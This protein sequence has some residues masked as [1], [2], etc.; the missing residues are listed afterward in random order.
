MNKPYPFAML[1]G[2]FLLSPLLPAE[3]PGNLFQMASPGTVQLK[4]GL[5][6]EGKNAKN[7]EQVNLFL[8]TLGLKPLGSTIALSSGT[9]IALSSDGM[10][11]TNA[12]VVLMSGKERSDAR[13]G[14]IKVFQQQFDLINGYTAY[15]RQ[16]KKI[17]TFTNLDQLAQDLSHVILESPI[18][19]QLQVNN[20]ETRA[21]RILAADEDRD[22]AL[23]QSDFID[24]KPL[25]LAD[26][27]AVNVGD[28]V[29]A[30]GYPLGSTL[31]DM[32]SQVV[33]TM[34]KGSITAIRKANLALQHS[35][36]ITHGNSGGPLINAAGDVVGINSAGITEGNNL[37][38]AIASSTAKQ[39]LVDTGH[40]DVMLANAG[41]PIPVF[42]PKPTEAFNPTR[43]KGM[44][45]ITGL[46][47]GTKVSVLSNDEVKKREFTAP[48]DGKLVLIDLPFG[49]LQI[50]ADV[51][52][53]NK[54]Y[55][56]RYFDT[57]KSVIVVGYPAGLM[58]RLD[59][60]KDYKVPENG[61]LELT[62]DDKQHTLDPVAAWG[63]GVQSQVEV[64]DESNYTVTFGSGALE[65]SGVPAGAEVTLNGV[66][67]GPADS[68]GLWSSVHAP[69]GPLKV[70]L[71]A[72]TWVA[73][74]ESV[75][76][77]SQ[78]VARVT[79]TPTP[80]AQLLIKTTQKWQDL[81]IALLDG[82]A[83]A[84]ELP[85]LED[86]NVI[87]LQLPEDT[88]QLRVR[89]PDDSA[90]FYDQPFALAV[91]K[92]TEIA[93]PSIGHSEAWVAEQARLAA[94]KKAQF[95]AFLGKLFFLG[96][97]AGDPVPYALM[98]GV[99]LAPFEL[100][101]GVS[102]SPVPVLLG[103]TATASFWFVK[104]G[105]LAVG[106]GVTA[107]YMSIQSSW[108]YGGKAPATL[109]STLLLAGPS[110]LAKWNGFVIDAGAGWALRHR[111]LVA[112]PADGI[113]THVL[114]GWYWNY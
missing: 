64:M 62:L 94:E 44:V 67:A 102:W 73:P 59:S 50:E 2:L 65:V 114:A 1:L 106:A 90:D 96:A 18:L 98:A 29:I 8:K 58:L 74:A 77:G 16:Q 25:R 13:Q 108:D 104:I 19:L 92:A 60:S 11:L 38:L 40:R 105:D 112:A 87:E 97:Q 55:Y 103:A 45:T 78:G 82:A 42:A 52:V 41:L 86:A 85:F 57:G 22:L 32:F 79:L 37:N 43:G 109:T 113:G 28:D 33:T 107:D 10:I 80:S 75:T 53:Y 71:K 91:G 88:Y 26:S 89:L 34:T 17:P 72:P 24:L 110:V 95:E 20:T 68:G 69:L 12:H 93:L 49:T 76:I 111:N 83:K 100:K 84:I 23:V 3:T 39:F 31:E 48:S 47:A 4:T 56:P 30:L 7:P 99:N 51:Q 9:G 54:L 14:L 70:G 27:A 15:Q 21:V 36:N 81:K 6:L 46:L 61:F 66:L 63:R 101:A 5:Q 35:A